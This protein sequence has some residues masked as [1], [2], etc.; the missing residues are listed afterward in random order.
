MPRVT[1]YVPDDLKVRMDVAG[2][3]VNWSAVA[4]RAFLEAILNQAVRKEQRD[5]NSVVERLRASKQ[6]F[7]SMDRE[8]GHHRGRQ[9][10]EQTADYMELKR[11]AN[12]EP[13]YFDFN[14]DGLKEVIDP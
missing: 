12:V 5:M 3:A 4:Q 8:H 11:I 10:A 9:W 7:E 1:I 2:E 14:L 6:R 13:S